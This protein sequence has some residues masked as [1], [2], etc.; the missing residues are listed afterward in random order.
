MQR[1]SPTRDPLP[2]V[3]RR[4]E[5]YFQVKKTPHWARWLQTILYTVSNGGHEEPVR[6]G[7]WG[8]GAAVQGLNP[9]KLQINPDNY[10]YLRDPAV[11]CV[12][13][14]ALFM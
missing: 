10:A 7:V 6:R 8:G 14:S 9:D 11:R 2:A 5:C 4:V 12:Y 1:K 13:D 3:T